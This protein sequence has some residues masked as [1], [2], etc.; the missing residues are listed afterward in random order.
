MAIE[1]MIEEIN[2]AIVASSDDEEEEEEEEEDGASEPEGFDS[3]DEEEYA[4]GRDP[5]E[6]G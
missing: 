6:D 5:F 4:A 2:A 1:F 3:C